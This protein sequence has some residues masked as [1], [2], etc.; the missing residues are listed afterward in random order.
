MAPKR[1]SLM[2]A[3]VPLPQRR[4]VVSTEIS[5]GNSSTTPPTTRSCSAEY[6]TTTNVVSVVYEA[7]CA[8]HTREGK[9][10][11]VEEN[12]VKKSTVKRW[13]KKY[14]GT[15]E[16]V[17]EQLMPRLVSSAKKKFL[18]QLLLERQLEDQTESV[19]DLGMWTEAVHRAFTGRLGSADGGL[20]GPALVR[21]VVSVGTSFK[22]VLAFMQ[23]SKL[24][25]LT[26]TERQRA[27]YMLA[28]LLVQHALVVA[29]R[30]GVPMSVKLVSQC[31]NNLAG[32]FDAQFPGY[33]EAGLAKMIARH[34]EHVQ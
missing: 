10:E 12:P 25:E 29:R 11:L 19:R 4:D 20:V 26:V 6:T 31:T 18:D 7:E 3:V 17:I 21:K 27:Y 32:V 9:M 1:V 23:S 2:R 14:S 8:R 34:P 33:L 13:E 16:E 28:E 24:S 30:S 15:P 22:P 5:R